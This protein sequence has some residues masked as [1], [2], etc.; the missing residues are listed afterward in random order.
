MLCPKC[1]LKTKVIDSRTSDT[2]YRRRRC[3]NCNYTFVTKEI[4][5][6]IFYLRK[7]WTDIKASKGSNIDE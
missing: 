7:I 4:E 1:N 5:S 2:T 6:D 3:T